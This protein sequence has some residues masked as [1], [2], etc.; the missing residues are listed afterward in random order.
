MNI[1]KDTLTELL[2]SNPMDSPDIAWLKNLCD[3]CDLCDISAQ[4]R[5]IVRKF[6]ASVRTAA[7]QALHSL[8]QADHLEA[9]PEKSK[10][11]KVRSLRATR[12]EYIM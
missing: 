5:R 8:K 7:N 2:S 12:L 1:L 9:V 10:K 3:L 11:N 6:R 4:K